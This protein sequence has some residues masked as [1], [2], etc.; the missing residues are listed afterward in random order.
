MFEKVR[1]VSCSA[2]ESARDAERLL[3][4]QIV[5]LLMRRRM[6]SMVLS[7][8][9]VNLAVQSSESTYTRVSTIKSSRK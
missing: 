9:L 4:G 7:S 2:L 6:L 1:P 5:I 8:T 3:D